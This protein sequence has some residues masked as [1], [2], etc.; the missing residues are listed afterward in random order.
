MYR[1]RDVK[2]MNAGQAKI[3]AETVKEVMND[4]TLKSKGEKD[5]RLKE[6]KANNIKKFMDDRKNIMIKQSKEKEKLK[7]RHEK[8]LKEIDKDLETVSWLF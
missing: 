1:H 7:I 3:S 5:R 6:K 2:E 8:E 4:K